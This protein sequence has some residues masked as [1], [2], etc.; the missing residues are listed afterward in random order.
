MTK[1]KA[2]GKLM[3]GKDLREEDKEEGVGLGE[4]DFFGEEKEKPERKRGRRK[5]S[6][7]VFT[8]GLGCWDFGLGGQEI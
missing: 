5:I 1:D 2:D 6:L 4:G 3:R 8:S 7:G